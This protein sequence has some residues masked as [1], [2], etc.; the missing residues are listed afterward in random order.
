MEDQ[1]GTVRGAAKQIPWGHQALYDS[2]PVGDGDVGVVA[3]EGMTQVL[4]Q[5]SNVVLTGRKGAG[6]LEFDAVLRSTDLEVDKFSLPRAEA[7]A[8]SAPL[9]LMSPGCQGGGPGG[10]QLATARVAAKS[11]LS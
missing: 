6:E 2:A 10:M 8:G 11:P 3:E 9:C 4:L 7:F 1:C 5:E